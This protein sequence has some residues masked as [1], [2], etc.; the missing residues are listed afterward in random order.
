MFIRA[1]ILAAF[2]L[3]TAASAGDFGP[4]MNA[5]R[6][7]WPDRTRLS[8][9]ANYRRSAGEI[10]ALAEAAGEG[11]TIVVLDVGD[12]ATDYARVLYNET[13]RI[14]PDYLVLLRDDP[15]YPEGVMDS[16]VIVRRLVQAGIPCLGTT[17]AAIRQGATFAVGPETGNEIL[18]NP[19][20]RGTINVTL[21]Q[22]RSASLR[23]ARIVMMAMK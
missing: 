17:P 23:A 14:R 3:A 2:G 18:V 19:E 21:P 8:V 13:R 6:S 15:C 22:G 5:A 16:T 1:A 11:C 4:L 9:V 7:T 20:A 12:G 10:Q